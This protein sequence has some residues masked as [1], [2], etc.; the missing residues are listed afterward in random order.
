MTIFLIKYYCNYLIFCNSIYS[1]GYV[2][3]VWIYAHT[4]IFISLDKKRF[5]MSV[6]MMISKSGHNKTINLFYLDITT[7]VHS[8]RSKLIG[9]YVLIQVN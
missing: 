1:Y 2:Y 6:M 3:I 4:H 8:V 7:M 9:D 5:F